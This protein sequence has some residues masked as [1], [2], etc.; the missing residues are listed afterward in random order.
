MTQSM[1]AFASHTGLFDGTA[2]AWEMRGVNARGL[3]LRLRLP[4][5]FS[6]LDA[7]LRKTLAARLSRG[8]VS[9]SLRLTAA[10]GHSALT[11]DDVQ[12]DA[13]LAAL[14][15]IQDRALGQGVTLAQPTAADVLSHRGVIRSGADQTAAEIA[16]FARVLEADFAPLLDA[17]CA[18]RANEG[19]ALHK[20]VAKQLESIAQLTQDAT[21]AAEARR[22]QHR[23]QLSVALSHVTS[24]TDIDED[25]LA[26][27]IAL[28][29]VKSDITE[30]IDRL[31]SHVAAARDL[32]DGDAPKGRK[33]DFLMQEFNREANTLCAKSQDAALTRIG[34][35]LKAVIDQLREQIQ[36]VE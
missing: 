10:E 36:N 11:V 28:L 16:D 35:D 22:P 31:H 29:A 8:N 1:T 26:Q 7:S 6:A 17:F 32:M 34:L 13:V 30:E 9:V 2:W 27:E 24:D 14:D 23:A 19:A 18:M 5:G 21:N 12:L 20:V 3:D 15:H 33:L 25:R 4:E